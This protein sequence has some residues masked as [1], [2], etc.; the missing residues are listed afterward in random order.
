MVTGT[1]RA[2]LVGGGG[3]LDLPEFR[4]ILPP[5]WLA[6]DTSVETTASLMRQVTRRLM[7]AHRVD[8]QGLLAG[9]VQ[10]VMDRVRA[11]GAIALVLPGPDAAPA[12]FAPA[13]LLVS[14]RTAPKGAT[15]DPFV[16]E[17]V[18]RRG[19]RPLDRDERF[20]RWVSRG[21][22]SV[23]GERLGNYFVEYLTPVPGS[24]RRRALHFAFS[25]AHLPD[26][27]PEQDERTRSWVALMDAHIA[28]FSWGAA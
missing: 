23:D 1:L 6:H 19:G 26:V 7:P 4:M 27:D 11:D 8:L 22:P 2:E 20:V 17:V 9:Q 15:L 3:G 13:S 18:Q 14:V 16:V 5:G 28:T 10:T 24:D 21:T 12:L 25:L